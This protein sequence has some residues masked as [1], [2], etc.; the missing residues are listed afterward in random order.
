[1]IDNALRGLIGKVCFV[2]LDDIIVYGR[3]LVEHNENL[4][5]VFQRLRENNLKLQPDKCEYLKPE[6]QYLGHIITEDG[7]KPNPEKCKSV[8]EFSTPNNI[9]QIRQFLGTPDI[10]ENL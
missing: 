5:I 10:I 6:L 3:T 2:Y 8:S 7:V 9:K 1:M 4:K